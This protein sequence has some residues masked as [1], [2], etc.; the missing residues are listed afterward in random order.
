MDCFIENKGAGIWGR[1][2][3]HVVERSPLGA[4]KYL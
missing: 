3:A 4:A 2:Y 1:V